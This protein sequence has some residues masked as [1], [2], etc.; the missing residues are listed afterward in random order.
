MIHWLSIIIVQSVIINNNCAIVRLIKNYVQI[1][2]KRLKS[3]RALSK[4]IVDRDF[5]RSEFLTDKR[6]YLAKI[7]RVSKFKLRHCQ[8]EQLYNSNKL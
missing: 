5:F 1:S 7:Q 2:A 3:S 6:F 4:T 8:G